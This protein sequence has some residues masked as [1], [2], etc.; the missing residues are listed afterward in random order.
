MNCFRYLG[1]LISADGYCDKDIRSRIEI[2]KKIFHDK[3]TLFTSK[4]NLKFKKRII[5]C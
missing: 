5:K 1:S 2:A 3:K 4:L